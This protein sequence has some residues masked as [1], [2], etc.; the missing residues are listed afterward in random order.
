MCYYQSTDSLL[1][2]VVLPS[3]T[4]FQS[5]KR[6]EMKSC[7]VKTLFIAAAVLL[8]LGLSH[9]RCRAAKSGEPQP[10]PLHSPARAGKMP[11][12]TA[13]R[14]RRSMRAYESGELT[15]TEVSHLLW[16][17]Q[18]VNRPGGFRTAPSA[19]AL[20]PLE[21]Y[22]AAGEVEGLP[23]GLYRYLPRE[24]ALLPVGSGDRRSEL[25]AAA[26]GQEC[27][28]EGAAVIVLSAV[29]GRTTRKYG[30]RGVRYVHIEVGGAAQNIYLQAASLGLGTVFI[31]AF[32]DDRVRSVLN[33]PDDEVPLGLMPLGRAVR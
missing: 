24:H 29:Y 4:V 7:G 17:A 5:V 18:G 25:C 8:M 13:L 14:E 22:L 20:Y 19:G 27:L 33:L 31:G 15:I 11:L 30:E 26:L 23:Q 16:A 21:L 28:N 10:V 9:N 32:D 2:F 3:K 6:W 12:E 1:L